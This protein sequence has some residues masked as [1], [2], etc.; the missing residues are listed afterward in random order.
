VAVTLSIANHDASLPVAYRLY[1][2]KERASDRK[3]RRN[4]GV[5]DA[6]S[7]KTKPAKAWKR[8]CPRD[9]PVCAFV[10]RIGI[11]GSPTV[12]R[13]NGP[14]GEKDPIKYWLSTLPEDVAFRQLVDIPSNFVP[15]KRASPRSMR[16]RRRSAV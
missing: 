1:L 4:V 2:P 14:D 10:L 15:V 12:G 8:N 6:I 13:R 9:W 7:F 3:R 5:P 16:S 11:T